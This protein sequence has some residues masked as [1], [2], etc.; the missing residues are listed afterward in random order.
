MSVHQLTRAAGSL[1]ILLLLYFRGPMH[2]TDFPRGYKM[3]FE[4]VQRTLA[5]LSQLGL[6]SVDVEN[7]F[8]FG[9]LWSLTNR[10]KKLIESPAYDWPGLFWQWTGKRSLTHDPE[11]LQQV[12]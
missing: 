11:Q 3:G 7:K 6:V 9:H 2:K 10:G 12:R 5:I 4:A 1:D 8:P